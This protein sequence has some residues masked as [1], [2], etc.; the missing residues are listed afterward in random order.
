[1]FRNNKQ[2][3]MINKK[4]VFALLLAVAGI[5]GIGINGRSANNPA[6]SAT[7]SPKI[8]VIETGLQV[9]DSGDIKEVVY[10][11]YKSLPSESSAVGVANQALTKSGSVLNLSWAP[12]YPSP[13][14]D[15]TDPW[16]APDA[17]LTMRIQP[18]TNNGVTQTQLTSAVQNSV[19][20]W[21]NAINQKLFSTLVIG[22]ATTASYEAGMNGYNSISWMK[23]NLYPTEVAHTRTYYQNDKTKPNYLDVLETDIALNP[24][25]ASR[26]NTTLKLEHAILH[27]TGHAIGMADDK[28]Y[29]GSP[30]YYQDTSLVNTVP[31]VT[32]TVL[33]YKYN[34]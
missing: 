34:Y 29:T 22:N 26:L 3:T 8:G 9:T 15:P 6:S 24:A 10:G 17:G 5:T 32:K 16:H 13:G 33:G 4:S 25:Y 12:Y 23:T 19:N 30:M 18:G 1:L 2:K 27:E 14:V 7:D 21:N 20:K 11:S 31:Y 28:W